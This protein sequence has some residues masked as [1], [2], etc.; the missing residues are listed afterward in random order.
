MLCQLL[1]WKHI[2]VKRS[3]RAASQRK[4]GCPRDVLEVLPF[5]VA[6]WKLEGWKRIATDLLSVDRQ[7]MF[8]KGS[9]SR[10]RWSICGSVGNFVDTGVRKA[11][12]ELQVS[13]HMEE[14]ACSGGKTDR[15]TLVET[16]IVD[17]WKQRVLSVDTSLRESAAALL[18]PASPSSPQRVRRLRPG[19]PA[20]ASCNIRGQRELGRPILCEVQW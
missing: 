14:A 2:S 7:P 5:F 16:E 8:P 11:R 1:Y 17:S 13:H 9:F 10:G 12:E 6:S 19:P 3:A 18:S 4:E 20:R 15:L